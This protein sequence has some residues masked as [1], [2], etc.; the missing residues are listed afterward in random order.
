M[1]LNLDNKLLEAL[2]G[3]ISNEVH[4]FESVRNSDHVVTD[5]KSLIGNKTAGVNGQFY[6][7]LFDQFVNAL[8]PG[9]LWMWFFKTRTDGIT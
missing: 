4:V 2:F 7:K 9:S 6:N 8:K 1:S 5:F 3:T